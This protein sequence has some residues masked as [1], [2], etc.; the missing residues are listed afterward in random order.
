MDPIPGLAVWANHQSKFLP[1]LRE[2][3]F[4]VSEVTYELEENRAIVFI[5]PRKHPST[6]YVLRNFSYFLP[7][8]K[9]I[10]VHGT[11]NEE[12]MRHVTSNIRGTFEFINCKVS[13]LPNTSYNTLFTHP[14]FWSALPQ[15]VLIAQTDTLLLKF[16]K[17][18]LDE[19]II[20]E[21]KYC[22]APWNYLCTRCK[23]PLDCGCGHMIDQKK[24]VEMSPN[25]VGNGGLS[26]R[27]SRTMQDLCTKF[28]LGT[29]PCKNILGKWG[30]ITTTRTRIE[31]T[32]NEDVFYC[33]LLATN[34]LPL[35]QRALDFAL[36]QC[37]PVSWTGKVPSVGAHKPW[38]YLPLPLVEAVL[39]LV[40]IV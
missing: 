31:G 35:R 12:F 18:F 6:E 23:K 10:I 7:S 21:I 13:N 9:I 17:S 14:L 29:E 34:D 15:W 38:M 25:M 28:C 27:N 36:E 2:K 22:G 39:N 5:E 16:A 3:T 30:A 26:F 32:S 33:S 11:E 4:K 20:D 24:L 8:W 1:L 40:E 19:L 37:Q